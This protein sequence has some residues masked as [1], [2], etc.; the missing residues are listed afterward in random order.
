VFWRWLRNTALAILAEEARLPALDALRDKVRCRANIRIYSE[1][2]YEYIVFW[3]RLRNT[4]L[5]ILAEDALRDK[6]I[7]ERIV[8]FNCLDVY[9]KSPDSGER[10]FK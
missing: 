1:R 7:G 2:I 5:A 6:V 3:R 10:Q 4:P 9:H 8:F